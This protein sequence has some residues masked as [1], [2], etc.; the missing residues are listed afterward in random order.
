MTLSLLPADVVKK[1]VRVLPHSL[2]SRF[3]VVLRCRFPVPATAETIS[4]VDVV[5]KIGRVVV[6]RA[7]G[8]ALCGVLDA[9][10]R[11]RQP[12]GKLLRTRLQYSQRLPS[13]L[14]HQFLAH[15]LRDPRKLG[16]FGQ[17]ALSECRH[18]V[19]RR[20][21]GWRGSGNG[22]GC[23][24]RRWHDRRNSRD[25]DIGWSWRARKGR[26]ANDRGH[27]CDQH[28]DRYTDELNE[29]HEYFPGRQRCG[30]RG[31]VGGRTCGCKR[32]EVT[33]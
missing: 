9:A 24:R 10:T 18:R 26:I 32:C 25:G 28:T 3:R 8:Y 23:D 6:P 19:D 31:S 5:G 30:H 7:D 21:A 11:Q 17:T 4:H 29:S 15:V 22:N 16:A 13:R 2:A 12:V 14:R 33:P 27:K 1:L 20:R